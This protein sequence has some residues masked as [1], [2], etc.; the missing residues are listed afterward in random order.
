MLGLAGAVTAPQARPTT[1]PAVSIKPSPQGELL[2]QQFAKDIKPVLTQYCFSC[3][4][5]G[6]HKGDVTL[7]KFSTWNEVQADKQTWQTVMD[8]L[9]Q[10]IMPP[11]EKP[12][13]PKKDK[14]LIVSWAAEAMDYID[15]TGPRDPGHLVIHRLNRNEYNNTIRDLVGVSDFKPA[16][17]FPADDTGYGFDNIGDVLTMSPLLAEKYLAAAEQVM[18]RAIQSSDPYAKKVKKFTGI[19]MEPTAGQTA[20]SAAWNLSNN[21]ELFKKFVFPVGAE[22]EIR[23]R[24]YGDQFGDEAPKMVLRLDGKDLLTF[25]V[26]ATGQFPELYKFR[27]KFPGGSHKVALAYTNNAV[28]RNNKDPKKRG[29]RNL[30]VMWMEIEGPFNA[31]PPPIPESHKKVLIATPGRDGPEDECAG[32]IVK[33][34]ATRAFRRPVTSEEMLGLMRL[35]RLAKG[36]KEPFEQAVKIPL[37]ACLCSPHFIFRVELDPPTNPSTPHPISD[38]ELA[39]RLSYFL[40][41]SMPDDEL[42][43]LAQSKTLHNPAVLNKQVKRMLTDPKAVELVHNFVGQWLELR[44]LDDWTPDEQR[45]PTFDEKLRRAMKKE[46]ELYF[47]TIIKEDRSILELLDS[48]YT[49][50]NERLAKHYGIQNVKGD[51]FKRVSLA[52][53]HRGGVLTMASVLTVTAMPSRTSPV[54]RGKFVLEQILGSPPPPPPPEV[55]NLPNKPEDVQAASM[56]QRLEKHRANPSCAVCHQRM[57]P[58]GFSMENFDAIGAWRDKDA[59]GHAIDT[60]GKLPN[61]QALDGPDG[62]RKV[63]VTKKAEFTRCMLEKMLT[64]AL[65]RGME[66]YDRCTVKEI[67]QS[68]E[69]NNYKFSSV[70]DGIVQSDAFLKRRARTDA[71]PT[72]TANREVIEVKR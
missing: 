8:V 70:V 12:Q 16:D 19:Q 10:G 61:G 65:G 37:I 5:N 20:E 57:D 30:I 59:G 41:S 33:S 3:H 9:A 42:M 14:D 63:L 45:F 25:D 21:G 17:D 72:T 60:S 66:E 23:I 11:E 56:R 1:L 49:Y 13:P 24:A 58:I 26:K 39:T 47:S 18:D 43:Q 55:P 54:K 15:C 40:W 44:N 62:L 38:Y 35:Y 27:S 46:A 29:D 64:Y 32:K 6:K 31:P 71:P 48:D 2:N 67:C 50:V 68:V 53:T 34:F 52:G 69:K 51:D 36:N 7:D 4:G 28:D 22:Y